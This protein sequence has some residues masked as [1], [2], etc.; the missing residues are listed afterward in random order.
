MLSDKLIGKPL[1]NGFVIEK[2]RTPAG[3]NPTGACHWT[4]LIELPSARVPRGTRQT[5]APKEADHD[6]TASAD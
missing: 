6:A 3:R 2:M 1:V 5:R 4:R